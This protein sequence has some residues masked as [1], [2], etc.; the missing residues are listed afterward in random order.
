MRL[1]IVLALALVAGPAL[2]GQPSEVVKYFYSNIGAEYDPARRDQ[3]VDPAKAVLDA[4]EKS[5]EPCL[6]FGLALDAQDYDDAILAKTLKLAEDLNGDTAVVTASF[7]LFEGDPQNDREI[8]WELKK[9]GADWKIFDVGQAEGSW[10][11]SEMSC[12]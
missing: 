6:D 5:E 11:L 12:Q 2:A 10:R 9:V 8:V 3:F 4:N 1:P 7:S